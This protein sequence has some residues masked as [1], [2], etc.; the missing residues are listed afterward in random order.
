METNI[1]IQEAV[2]EYNVT[3]R[4][5]RYYEEIGLLNAQRNEHNN[6][7]YSVED[8]VRIQCLVLYRSMDLS[9]DDIRQLIEDD[10]SVAALEHLCK[11]KR[12]KLKVEM[13]DKETQITQLMDVCNAMQGGQIK[14]LLDIRVIAKLS[15]KRIDHKSFQW[16]LLW[17]EITFSR[18]IIAMFLFLDII[19]GTALLWMIIS[20]W[21]L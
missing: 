20:E 21:I 5:L 3:A 6:R 15:N 16:I 10:G 7:M 4:A 14:S 17:K 13:K 1:S 19:V 8:Q 9:L 12:R 18:V 11:V 2:K